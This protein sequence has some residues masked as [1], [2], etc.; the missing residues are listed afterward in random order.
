MPTERPSSVR[1][2]SGDLALAGRHAR[3]ALA[4][5]TEIMVRQHYSPRSVETYVAWI[6][7]FFRFQVRCDPNK[8]NHDTVA[9]F[10]SVL[11]V[12]KRVSASTQNQARSALVFYFRHVRGA[13]LPM[14]EGV[15]PASRPRR[16]PVVLSGDEVLAVLRELSG[17][18]RL[19][20]MLL[21]GS[22]LR[23]LEALS[24]R[25]KDL[26]FARS[27]LI[28]RS[29]K[30]DKDRATVFP[31]GIHEVLRAHL[32]K[33]KRL[34][35]RDL[36]AGAGHVVLPGALGRKVPSASRA[37][38]W[39]WVFPATTIYRDV[40]TGERRRHHLHETA[41]QRGMKEAVLRS[42]VAK[43]ATCH[44]L[45]HSFAT[46]LLERGTDIRTLQELLGHSDLATTMI[47]THVL[48]RGASAVR[49]P[50]EE[51]LASGG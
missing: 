38:E 36:V 13:P 37:W 44:T 16:L 47:Y 15:T 11:A 1:A 9:Q 41:M 24:L 25:V 21:Y 10:L 49:S 51:L 2:D 39:Q 46:H 23:L 22:G 17:A 12:K 27:Q 33:V 20:G 48:E 14:L 26:D 50:L 4:R 19:V 31:R 6:R 8:L 30:G 3:D 45:R 28:V 35:E 5:T 42:G 40:E 43:R 7:R 32:A 18:K 29:G 34:H